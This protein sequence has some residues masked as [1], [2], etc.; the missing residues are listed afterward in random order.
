MAVTSHISEKQF[1]KKSSLICTYKKEAICYVQEK[2]VILTVALGHFKYASSVIN[3]NS[4]WKM[5]KSLFLS[6]FCLAKKNWIFYFYFA[7]ITLRDCKNSS[8]GL[9]PEIS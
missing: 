2:E 5:C 9:I 8:E 6:E 3:G 1:F 4:I 7:L